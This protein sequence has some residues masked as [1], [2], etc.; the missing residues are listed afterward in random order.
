M[1]SIDFLLDVI[2]TRSSLPTP[3]VR[4]VLPQR[5]SSSGIKTTNYEYTFPIRACP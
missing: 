5:L 3:G 2:N 1:K 4:V